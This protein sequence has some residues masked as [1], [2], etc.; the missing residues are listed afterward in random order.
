MTA[1]VKQDGKGQKV[2]Y[3]YRVQ[4]WAEYDKALVNRGSLT[5]WFDEATIREGWTR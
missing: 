1:S 3:D 4:N 2:K 5:V